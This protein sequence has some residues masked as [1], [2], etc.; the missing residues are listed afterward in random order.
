MRRVALSAAFCLAAAAAFAQIVGVGRLMN[1]SGPGV[2]VTP[3]A[4]IDLMVD[5]SVNMMADSSVK[6]EVQ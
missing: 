5:N 2:A 3:P 1:S 4:P 6:L